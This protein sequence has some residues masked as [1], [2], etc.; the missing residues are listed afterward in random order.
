[1]VNI[2]TNRHILKNR[3][4]DGSQKVNDDSYNSNYGEPCEEFD[5][6]IRVLF[7]IFFFS[8]CFAYETVEKNIELWW[9]SFIIL[10]LIW[11]LRCLKSAR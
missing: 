4:E 8:Q 3:Y 1:M 10:L 6:L 9:I 7:G 5:L 11:V 2:C